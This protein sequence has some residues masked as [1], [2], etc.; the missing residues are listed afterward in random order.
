MPLILHEILA[1]QADVICLQE[2]D[3]LVY[4]TLLKPV[5]EHYNY[6]G[7]YSVKQTSATREGCAMFWSL[8]RFQKATEEDC[9]T[10]GLS[11][12][13]DRYSKQTQESDLWK[14]CSAPVTQLLQNR[15]DLSELINTKLGHVVQIA[16]L[17]DLDGNPLVVA[18]THLFFH[19][20]GS[21][22]R[23]LQC[24]AIAHQLMIEQGSDNKPFLLCGD[25]NTSLQYCAKLLME[26][27]M[28]KNFRGNR[29]DLNTFWWDSDKKKV[30]DDDFPELRLPDS[31]PDLA[32]GY[33][34]PPEF[35]HYVV[36]FNATIDHILMSSKTLSGDLRPLRQAE[37]PTVE[38]A[39]RHQAM[40]S[41]CFPSDHVSVVCDVEWIPASAKP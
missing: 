40:P 4:N 19:P 13:I 26:K 32:T 41:P 10:F 12:L 6:Q 14:D 17:R 21:H 25:F 8:E 22:I 23:N 11:N 35:T 20:I 18:N 36:G 38:Q 30:H 37:M 24:F 2:V 27:H 15:P 33:P 3:E 9:K 28:P 5:L 39:T 34:D 29:V 7:Y 31:F 1:H 16:S